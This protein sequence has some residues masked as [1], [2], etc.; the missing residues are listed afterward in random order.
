MV[1]ARS[2]GSLGSGGSGIPFL[3]EQYRQPLV[4]VSPSN[5][6]VAVPLPQ[7]SGR[8][9]QHAS[10]QTVVICNET[11]V[12]FDAPKELI[13][14]TGIISAHPITLTGWTWQGDGVYLTHG[15]V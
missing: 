14:L 3:T 2:I 9:G 1:S 5:I 10:S 6:N 12:A 4:Q 8:L 15:L 7:H 13:Q 11:N